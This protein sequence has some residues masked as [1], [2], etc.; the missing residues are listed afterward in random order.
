ME[1]YVRDDPGNTATYRDLD[2]L[3]LEYKKVPH[4]HSKLYLNESNGIVTS[5]NLLL[6]SEVNS[7]E[8]GYATE[9]WE[10]YNDLLRF[11][12][13]YIHLGE[14]VQFDPIAGRKITDPK[15]LMHC[16]RE[17]LRIS[18]KN[19]WLWLE[20][21]VLHIN[22]GRSNYNISV[23]NCCLRITAR[24]KI[25]F[26]TKQKG[27]Q[28][29]S[30]IMRKVGDLTAMKIVLE[31]GFLTGNKYDPETATKTNILHLSGLAHHTIRST[32]ITGIL[33]DE[34]AYIRESVVRFIEATDD[35]VFLAAIYKS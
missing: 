9:T 12:H 27:V 7:L 31:Q 23:N 3:G 1:I 20:G 14:P 30:S 18:G 5:M 34:S 22:T 25:A 15:E 19:S 24:L 16:I 4:L 2:H 35:Q 17:K 21:N 10:E 6:S 28:H 29:S 32:C 13:K 8:I 11:Y 33:D 26:T